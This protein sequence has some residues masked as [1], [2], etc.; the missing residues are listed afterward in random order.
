MCS[1]DLMSIIKPL[2]ASPLTFFHDLIAGTMYEYYDVADRTVIADVPVDLREKLNSRAQSNFTANISLPIEREL[3]ALSDAERYRILRER[4]KKSISIE[5]IAFKLKDA[6]ALV[7]MLDALPLKDENILKQMGDPGQSAPE[8]TRSYLLTN[9][10]LMRLPDSMAKYVTGFDIYGT[11]LEATPV[12][13]LLT[14]QNKG[15]LIVGQNYEETGLVEAVYK[16]LL[17]MDIDAELRDDGR[18]RMDDAAV[19]GFEVL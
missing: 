8:A 3:M 10:G 19:R 7:A 13:I 15:M 12:F 9:I 6:E 2:G 14:Y 18:V 1:S 16:K 4:L 17:T 5:N 11:N